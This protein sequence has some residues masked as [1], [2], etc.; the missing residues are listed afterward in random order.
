[1]LIRLGTS[2]FPLFTSAL[3]ECIVSNYLVS[4]SQI[5]MNEDELDFPIFI[6][7]LGL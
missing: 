7:M 6:G 3:E 5:C 2:S 1:M 4:I